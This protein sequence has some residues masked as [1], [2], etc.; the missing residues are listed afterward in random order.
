VT[1][2]PWIELIG[3]SLEGMRRLSLLFEE[4][5]AQGY[6]AGLREVYIAIQPWRD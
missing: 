6:P 3:A 2:G 5:L 4:I 1:W